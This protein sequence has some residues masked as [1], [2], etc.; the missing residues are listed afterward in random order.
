[1]RALAH[2]MRPPE[3]PRPPSV[4]AL[5]AGALA[6]ALDCVATATFLV[7]AD[8]YLV[9]GN[10]AGHRL[11]RG[12]GA[13]RQVHACL[14]ARRADEAKTL[15][16]GLV[17]VAASRQAEL[18]R[19][20]N[21]NGTARLL[22]TVSPVP[23]DGLVTVCVVDLQASDADFAPWFRQAFQLSVQNAE[24]AA[25]LLSGLSLS[26]FST[27]KEVTLGATRTRLKKL[28]AATGTRSQA[29][30]V[31]ALLRAAPLELSLR[32]QRTLLVDNFF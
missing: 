22:I 27:Q 4:A 25:S 21:R 13:L 20:V 17:R 3:A 7:R 30:L 19:F 16:T 15:T 26:E 31:A 2:P 14:V 12:G 10:H 8:G 18:L 24:L 1:M 9:Y 29:A 5:S 28:F 23:D 32:L 11:L 6:V